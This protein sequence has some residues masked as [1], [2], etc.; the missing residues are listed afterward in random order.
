[1]RFLALHTS[2][3]LSLYDHTFRDAMPDCTCI[4]IHSTYIHWA[5]EARNGLYYSSG[6]GRFGGCVPNH[7]SY[8]ALTPA[9][10]RASQIH[11]SHPRTMPCRGP[12][13]DSRLSDLF[14]PSVVLF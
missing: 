11:A 8:L 10:A 9:T 5:E 14:D 4:M 3:E 1:M 12:E 13:Q 6:Q 7:A 2:F